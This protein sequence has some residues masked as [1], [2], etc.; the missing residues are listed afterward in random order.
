MSAPLRIL[1]LEDDPADTDLIQVLLDRDGIDCEVTR[2]DSEAAFLACLDEGA[3]DV[4]LADYTLPGFDGLSALR[5]AIDRRPDLPF[6]FVSGTLGEDVAIE[7]LKIGATDYVLKARLSRLGPSVRRALREAS[8]RAERRRAEQ[9]LRQS[10][11]YLAAAE[12][13][14]RTGSFGWNV[15]SGD[16]FWSDETF[17]IFACEPTVKPTVDFVIERTHPADRARV[18]EVIDRA[19]TDASGFDLEH[20]LLLPD[21]TVKWLRVV[22]HPGNGNAAADHLLLGAVTDVTAGKRADEALRESEERFR[23]MADALTE[24][25]WIR[26]LGPERVLYL[27]PSFERIWRLPMAELRE[28]PRLWMD[29]IHPEDK[30]RV[31]DL[32]ARWI[33][34]DDVSYDVEYRI[35]HPDGD[36]RWIHARGVLSRDDE[37]QPI[38]ASGISA[39][40]TDRKRAQ[41]RLEEALRE[42]K[43]LKDQLYE[44]NVAL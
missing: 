39:D 17:R 16:I 3:I 18:L 1:S 24:A 33:S 2:V 23:T 34:G 7:A 12:R 9:A 4:I 32:Y 13:L 38:R 29:A 6:I 20:R 26:G 25:I 22:A 40:I 43:K 35:T 30:A 31:V 5:I 37:G 21:G 42:I 10:E 27:S 36:V 44:E 28:H 15:Q 8:E 14:S 41:E 19:S 11:T